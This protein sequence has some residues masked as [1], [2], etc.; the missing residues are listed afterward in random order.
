MFTRRKKFLI[1]IIILLI[2]TLSK[3]T[4]NCS[5]MVQ[6]LSI[7]NHLQ[8]QS[9]CPNLKTLII[10]VAVVIETRFTGYRS[11]SFKFLK[12]IKLSSVVICLN[13]E[14]V[15][16]RSE[17]LPHWTCLC[18]SSYWQHTHCQQLTVAKITSTVAEKMFSEYKSCSVLK[19]D[20]ADKCSSRH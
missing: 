17:P 11:S 8:L 6:H 12:R 10:Y 1:L 15:I 5:N 18:S 9:I 20:G 13:V 16:L 4:G 3:T 7:L 14:F 2:S 19:S